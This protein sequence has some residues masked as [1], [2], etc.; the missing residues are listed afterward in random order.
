V[1]TEGERTVRE[2]MGSLPSANG[3]GVRF[4]FSADV[5]R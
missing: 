3:W 2:L 5:S 4:T 1:T